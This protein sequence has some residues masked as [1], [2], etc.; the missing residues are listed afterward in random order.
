MLPLLLLGLALVVGLLLLAQWFVETEPRRVLAVLF[1]GGGALVLGAV[2][3]LAVTG[4]L[5]WA[6]AALGVLVPWGAR[7][8][9]GIS[10]VRWLA[11]V[12]GLFGILTGA[13]LAGGGAAGNR[14]GAAPAGGQASR[15]DSRFLTMTLDHDSGTLTGWLRA[16]RHAGR[17]LDSLTDAALA[18]VVAEV[19][20][21]PDSAALMA[22]WLARMRPDWGG[23]DPTAGPGPGP[24]AMGDPGGAAG[25]GRDSRPPRGEPGGLSRAE[26]LA[27]LGLTEATADSAT[28]RAA[29]RR[30]MQRLHPDAGGSDWMAAKLNQARDRLLS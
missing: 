1:W 30:L 25:E 27:I 9:H 5:G 29:H 18:E 13:G 19:A 12:L 26:A 17:S 7:L 28:I 22:T 2:I 10:L 24:D 6:A 8:M 14:F 15:I 20:I 23:P 4:R 16:G 3:A 11:R 21:D